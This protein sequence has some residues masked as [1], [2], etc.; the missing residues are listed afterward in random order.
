MI[1][2]QLQREL[3]KDP[4]NATDMKKLW[5]FKKLPD[6]SLSIAGY[7]GEETDISIPP[8]NGTVPV[9]AIDASAFDVETEEKKVIDVVDKD[10]N[11]LGTWTFD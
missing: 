11:A 6:G 7:K 10:E 3:M 2:K 5:S 4:Y 1:E 9:T 8:R